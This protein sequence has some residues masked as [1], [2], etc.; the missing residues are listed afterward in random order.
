MMLL[1]WHR[2]A[3]SALSLIFTK[4]FLAFNSVSVLDVSVAHLAKA[5]RQSVVLLVLS[6]K[7]N[8]ERD[9]ENQKQ[10][11]V[12]AT[13]IDALEGRCSRRHTN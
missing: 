2:L 12:D 7:A 9:S 3:P 1:A 4:T 10:R 13:D 8:Q 11:R 6:L 5:S